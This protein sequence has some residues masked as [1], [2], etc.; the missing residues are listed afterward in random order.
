MGEIR[1]KQSAM[2][3]FVR[4]VM[5]LSVLALVA[6]CSSATMPQDLRTLERTG[7]P[8]DAL[9]CPPGGC[10]A[11]ADIESPLFDIPAQELDAIART[12]I[13]TRPRT[14]VAEEDKTLGQTVFVQRSQVFGFPDTIWVQIVDLVPRSSLILYSRS[15]YG[16]WDLGVNLRRVRELLAEIEAAV[17]ASD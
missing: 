3:L 9:A 7:A 8:N 16:Y 2:I 15:N 14:E 11:E 17:A 13:S 1:G 6:G 4:L 5:G 10:G 12:V